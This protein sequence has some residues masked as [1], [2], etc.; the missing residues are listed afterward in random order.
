M[1]VFIRLAQ[2]VV[3]LSTFYGILL[4]GSEIIEQ[5]EL[6]QEPPTYNS[7]Q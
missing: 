2:L 5:Q 4:I 7:Q 6:E 3:W 1:D